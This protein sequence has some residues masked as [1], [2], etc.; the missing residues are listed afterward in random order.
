VQT[1]RHSKPRGPSRAVLPGKGLMPS[2]KC[3]YRLYLVYRARADA[4]DVFRSQIYAGGWRQSPTSR[5]LAAPKAPRQ[6]WALVT[7]GPLVWLTSLIYG[8][9]NLQNA[10]AVCRIYSM[11]M[12]TIGGLDKSGLQQALC[13]RCVVKTV[14]NLMD[15]RL[16]QSFMRTGLRSSSRSFLDSVIASRHKQQQEGMDGR[17]HWGEGSPVYVLAP[18]PL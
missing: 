16:D 10:A 5:V 8:C 2:L 17:V 18:P 7:R 4:E 13:N 6:D 14:E 9:I 12:R 1:S 3:I 15:L 11:R